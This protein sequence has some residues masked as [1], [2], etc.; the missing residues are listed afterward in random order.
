MKTKPPKVS[1]PPDGAWSRTRDLG[2]FHPESHFCSHCKAE[3]PPGAS[4]WHRVSLVLCEICCC[5]FFPQYRN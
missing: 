2:P 4:L 1:A 5:T 3:I